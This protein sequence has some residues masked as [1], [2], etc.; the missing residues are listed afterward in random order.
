[1]N[2]TSYTLRLNNFWF[3]IGAMLNIGAIFAIH[4]HDGRPIS[5]DPNQDSVTD[6][7]EEILNPP[8]V[9]KNKVVDPDAD[10]STDPAIDPNS[11]L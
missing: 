7:L 2:M 3:N 1:M 11:Q 6:E 9:K 8:G 10:P 5:P 4:P